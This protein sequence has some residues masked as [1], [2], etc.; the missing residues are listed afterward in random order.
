MSPL[1][2]FLL[3]VCMYAAF[4]LFFTRIPSYLRSSAF[5][6][7]LGAL[8]VLGGFLGSVYSLP[9]TESI[10]ISGGNLN[11]GA[12][13]M[14]I[15][16][17]VILE[18][19]LDILRLV[20][21]LI[22]TIN[23]FKL[24]L[25]PLISL[26]LMS[27]NVINPFQTSPSIFQVSIPA[28][29]LGAT[30]IISELIVFLF[31]FSRVK[32]QIHSIYILATL[33]IMFYIMILVID[34]ILFPMLAFA[35]DPALIEVIYGNVQGKLII[36]GVYAIPM[37]LFLLTNQQGF[38]KFVAAEPEFGDLFKLSRQALQA[39]LEDSER[40]YRLLIE[41]SPYAIAIYQRSALAFANEATCRL[42]GVKNYKGLVGRSLLDF[43]PS[44]YQENT[45]KSFQNALRDEGSIQTIEIELLPADNKRV[46]IELSAVHITYQGQPAVQIIAKDISERKQAESA[47]KEAKRLQAELEK[48]RELAA[49]KARFISMLVHDFRTPVTSITMSSEL[50][51]RYAQGIEAI[52]IH[53]KAENIKQIARD[54]DKQIS[55]LL[56]LNRSEKALLNF[57]PE[58]HNIVEFCRAIFSSFGSTYEGSK[59]EFIFVTALEKAT[60]AYDAYLV[61]RMVQNLLSNAVKYSPD[62]GI[63][64]MELRKSTHYVEII[65][66]DT[67][68]GIPEDD[69]SHI[70]DFLHR[71][72]NTG[73]IPGTGIGLTIVKQIVD[74]HEGMISCQSTPG[75]GTR[76][77]VGL[78]LKAGEAWE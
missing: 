55:D 20:I 40:R 33:Y 49:L 60:I 32:K 43:L 38:K 7:Y 39:A 45:L 19:D 65:I 37:C 22:V 57:S 72:S 8:Y 17:L 63:V 53:E 67:G 14:T 6:V 52:K 34:G 15:I 1:S 26:A 23:I 70:F 64:K 27:E 58:A 76:F 13:M 66:S 75:K 18:G 46:P 25:F 78:P 36:G 2:I 41:S 42:L 35:T 54:L 77:E 56:E 59:F 69:L 5:Y 29:L 24:S 28:V 71:A 31:V 3:H 11:Y 51:Q 62:G 50:V 30:L 9:L 12:F 61:E 47:A 44:E 48:Q 16:L 74:K 10:I 68:M 73:V 4:P 21:R